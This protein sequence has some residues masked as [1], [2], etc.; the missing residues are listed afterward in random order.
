[1][2]ILRQYETAYEDLGEGGWVMLE[3][4]LGLV[5]YFV[6]IPFIIPDIMDL[7]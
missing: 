4:Y 1:M 2:R 6:T 3:Q 5:T 7:L